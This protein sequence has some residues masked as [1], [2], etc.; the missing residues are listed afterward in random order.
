MASKV[1]SG[2][3]APKA[4]KVKRGG[5]RSWPEPR[6]DPHTA[7]AVLKRSRSALPSNTPGMTPASAT[8]RASRTRPPQKR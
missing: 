5:R 1:T 2:G 4:N 8:P 7:A 6:P 3:T